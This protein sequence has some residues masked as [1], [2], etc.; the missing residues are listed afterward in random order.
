[1][2][3]RV[4][5]KIS[6][7]SKVTDIDEKG[8]VKFI[9]SSF[10]KRDMQGDIVVP[11]AY[12]KT[13]VE[14]FPRLRHLIDH[15]TLIGIVKEANETEKGLE[16]VSKLILGTAAGK[17]AYETY[18]A[19]AESTQKIEHS[20]YGFAIQTEPVEKGTRGEYL[21]E[22]E[23][24]DVSTITKWGAN[25]DTPMISVKEGDIEDKNEATEQPVVITNE[26]LNVECPGCGL[27]FNYNS[28]KE[29]T[30]ET[31]VTDWARMMLNWITNQ[32]V[33]NYIQ[34]LQPEVAASVANIITSMKAQNDLTTY[35]I[36]PKCG[37]AVTKSN[38]INKENNFNV[39]E[40]VKSL[41]NLVKPVKS[42][43][44]EVK[45]VDNFWNMLQSIKV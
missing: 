16:I 39:L 19:F 24:Y 23:L 41:V 27:I 32:E 37:C 21:K 42:T 11:G 38:T 26:I 14:N 1:M 4:T 45:P 6:Y 3:M 25:P 28:L 20:I 30:L 35:V 18:K 9:A 17:E 12:K 2:N 43:L 29:S 22:I 10:N 31:R 13:I 7:L 5:K 33:Y 34:T 44:Q 8:I 36:C 15:K 40:E